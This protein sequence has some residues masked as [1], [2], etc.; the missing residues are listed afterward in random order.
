MQYVMQKYSLVIKRANICLPIVI[1]YRHVEERTHSL[2]YLV[3]LDRVGSAKPFVDEALRL[4]NPKD[5]SIFTLALQRV[6]NHALIFLDGFDYR[7]KQ[8]LQNRYFPTPKEQKR[9]MAQRMAN[10]NRRNE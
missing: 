6:V 5:K 10:E 2:E 3:A 7:Q 4:V 8:Q 9:L 1:T